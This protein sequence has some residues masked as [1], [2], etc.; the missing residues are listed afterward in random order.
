MSKRKREATDGEAMHGLKK[1]RR[2]PQNSERE[3]HAEGDGVIAAQP[4]ASVNGHAIATGQKTE[5]EKQA[6]K[7]ARKLAKREK[8]RREKERKVELLRAGNSTVDVAAEGHAE[9]DGVIAAQ[10]VASVNGH[11]I[12]TGQKTE[13][14]KQ[15]AKLARKLAKREKRR[16]EKERKVE[17]LGAGNSTVD[18]AAAASKTLERLS[19][20]AA[21]NGAVRAF[22][23]SA[24]RVSDAVGGRLLDLDPL[25][26]SDE[27]YAVILAYY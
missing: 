20:K 21:E 16:R 10:P 19:N 6:A 26:S 5:A 9:G 11:A 24:W 18:V 27:K 15:A 22:E 7:L 14:E 12:A 17:L 8:R 4:V 25:F 23:D 2:D 3:E 13:A 1:V